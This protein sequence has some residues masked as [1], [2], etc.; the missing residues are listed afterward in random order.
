M[1]EELAEGHGGEIIGGR[2]TLMLLACSGTVRSHTALGLQV[3]DRTGVQAQCPL[4]PAST[5]IIIG[6]AASL[7]SLG[8]CDL[9]ITP[10]WLASKAD[11][12]SGLG[13]FAVA[14]SVNFGR[15]NRILSVPQRFL[16]QP[17]SI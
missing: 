5:L 4:T 3:Q 17:I 8:P 14:A 10:D 6:L 2:C 13:A 9:T 16:I 15:W 7:T 12:K 1:W 11:S